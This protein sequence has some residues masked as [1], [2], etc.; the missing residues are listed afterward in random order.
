MPLKRSRRP[1]VGYGSCPAKTTSTPKLPWPTSERLHSESARE[2]EAGWIWATRQTGR[3]LVS[4][5]PLRFR[6]IRISS[7][8][9]GGV[10]SVVV[11]SPPTETETGA[12]AS[13]GRR[14]GAIEPLTL[15]CRLPLRVIEEV[16]EELEA[17]RWRFLPFVPFPPPLL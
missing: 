4:R 9:G 13:R 11:I 14:S 6:S 15:T 12:V 1:I 3:P 8:W 7:S 5:R 16:E 10:W 17:G 2:V